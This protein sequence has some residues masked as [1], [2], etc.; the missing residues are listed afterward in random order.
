MIADLDRDGT[1]TKN[2]VTKFLATF[3]DLD[4]ES[5]AFKQIVSVAH[6]AFRVLDLD[7]DGSIDAF[8]FKE[9][10]M[11][12][13]RA[14]PHMISGMLS[15]IH[16]IL[17]HEHLEEMVEQFMVM[18]TESTENSPIDS[19]EPMENSS[20]DSRVP[21]ESIILEINSRIP[22]EE[23]IGAL[24]GLKQTC[25]TISDPDED[26]P[27][28]HKVWMEIEKILSI[29]FYQYE[30]FF[31]NAEESASNNILAKQQ[32]M[33]IGV[34]CSNHVMDA[35]KI[36]A[37]KIE[38][39]LM[40]MVILKIKNLQSEL[41]DET[42][43]KYVVLERSMVNDL[44]GTVCYS[45]HSYFKESGIERILEVLLNL[46]DL[47]NTGVVNILEMQALITMVSDVF[48]ADD[49]EVPCKIEEFQ[50]ALFK[51]IAGI[52]TENS[53]CLGKAD[54]AKC[55]QIF[56]SFVFVLLQGSLD[57]VDHAIT[58]AIAPVVNLFLNLKG[59]A[60][61]GSDTNLTNFDVCS[62]ILAAGIAQEDIA[63]IG[64][65]KDLLIYNENYVIE[66]AFQNMCSNLMHLIFFW[67][68]RSTSNGFLRFAL[69]YR[70]SMLC[71]FVLP[72]THT[73]E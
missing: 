48:L 63:A 69:I 23:L 25:E 39:N 56:G 68:A 18:L 53:G 27:D 9:F 44:L 2:E 29:S 71:G 72:C 33:K 3:Q 57:F 52:D 11:E 35:I 43:I 49:D 14:L 62:A 41:D 19:G 67:G 13:C 66:K 64:S 55:A 42:P 59:Q 31:S 8:E 6:A 5:S 60:L 16:H 45:I 28:L 65:L 32:L 22:W 36:S 61:G 4:S 26:S 17:M 47:E 21:I 51:L 40:D 1:I 70:V 12:I 58:A 24:R 54:I 30:L 37:K 10:I 34:Q 73:L 50:R 38:A 7:G 46:L 15:E 20:I